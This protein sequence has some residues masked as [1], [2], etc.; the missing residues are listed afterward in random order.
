MYMLTSIYIDVK[1]V[2]SC[3]KVDEPEFSITVVGIVSV[4]LVVMH[5]RLFVDEALLLHRSLQITGVTVNVFSL[6][7]PTATQNWF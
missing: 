5:D 3:A 2:L 6:A 4:M 7:S 1:C